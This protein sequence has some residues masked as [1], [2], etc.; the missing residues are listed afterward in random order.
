[1]IDVSTRAE[2]LAMMNDLRTRFGLAY[3]YITHDLSTARFF[4]DRLAVMYLGR[5]VET[6]PAGRLLER[7][8]HPYT[9][10]L[11]AAVCEPLSGR[12]DRPMQLPIRGDLPPAATAAAPAG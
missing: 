9:R 3:L 5:I 7:P 6:G 11:I 12:V 4:A 8:L 10:A 2:V 1:M